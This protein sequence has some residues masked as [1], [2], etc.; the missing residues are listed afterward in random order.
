MSASLTPD[1]LVPLPPWSPWMNVK[2]AAL[3]LGRG[4]RFV[5]KEI[6]AGRLRAAIIGGRREVMTRREWC[7]AW[8]E[9]LARVVP[10]PSRSRAS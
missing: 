8:V 10:S 5:R 7:D 1:D 2:V 3:Y 4:R 6:A 9:T